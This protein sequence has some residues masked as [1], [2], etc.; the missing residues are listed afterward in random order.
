MLGS[1]VI[2]CAL[3]ITAAFQISRIPRR[4]S[5]L[6]LHSVA[7]LVD[8]QESTPR[9]VGVFDE[10][11]T[12]CGVQRV[13]GFQLIQTNEQ[14]DDDDDVSVVTTQEIPANCPVLFVPNEMILSSNRVVQELGRLHDAEEHLRGMGVADQL[15]EFYL[16]IKLL[17]EY[18]KGDESP[19]FPWLNALPRKFC[20]GVAMTSFCL[21]CLTPLA[22]VLAMREQSNLMNIDVS[23]VPFLSEE[24]KN[25]P[26]LVKWA[27]QIVCTRSF[28]ASDGSPDLFQTKEGSSDLRIPPMADMFNHGSEAEVELRYDEQGN[29]YAQ[30]TKNVPAGSALSMSYEDATNPSYLFMRYGFV[31]ESA[32]ATF[33]KIMMPPFV[34]QPLQDLGCAHNRMLFYKETGEV[35]QEVWDVLLYQLLGSVDDNSREEFYNAHMRG[36]NETKQNYHRHFWPQTSAKLLRHLDTFLKQV[37]DITAKAGKEDAMENPRLP[38]IMRHNNFVKAIFLKVRSR[39]FE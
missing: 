23:S 15:R 13:E 24:T 7:C 27:F 20:N 25:N 26:N 6:R 35:S 16:M 28:Q 37:D 31:D 11:A 33:C 2:A 4:P 17:V 30:T 14:D 34:S 22:A 32:P 8:I 9:D 19:W 39:Y 18:E 29:L 36:D 21:E 12:Q 38:L 10:W 5:C 1:P 3:N